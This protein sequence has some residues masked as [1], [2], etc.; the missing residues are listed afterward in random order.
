VRRGNSSALTVALDKLP[1]RIATREPRA[2]TGTL[3]AFRPV[4]AFTKPFW[5][6]VGICAGAGD[7]AAEHSNTINSVELVVLFEYPRRKAAS[8]VSGTPVEFIPVSRFLLR[9]PALVP[10]AYNPIIRACRQTPQSRLY[11]DWDCHS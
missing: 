3:E 6:I 8:Y 4:A 5:P 10:A 9:R 1:P 11:R 2:A 7:H